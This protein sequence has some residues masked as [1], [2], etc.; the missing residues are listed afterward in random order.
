[1]TD[2]PLKRIEDLVR[3]GKAIILRAPINASEIFRFSLSSVNKRDLLA[4]HSSIR[5]GCEDKITI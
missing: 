4:V 5:P 2:D 3:Q 1:M